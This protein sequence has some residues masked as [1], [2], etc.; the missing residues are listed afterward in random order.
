MD[1]LRV[2]SQRLKLIGIIL[3]ITE[4]LVY[5]TYAQVL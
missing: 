4:W 1:R 2:S 5:I 3:L